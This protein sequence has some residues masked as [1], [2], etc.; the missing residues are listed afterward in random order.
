M[1]TR[2]QIAKLLAEAPWV[3]SATLVERYLMYAQF[4]PKLDIEHPL[5]PQQG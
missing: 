4:F 5:T 3:F 2:G 1:Q